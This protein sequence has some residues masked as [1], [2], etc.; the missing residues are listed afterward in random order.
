MTDDKTFNT[1]DRKS[2]LYTA[3]FAAAAVLIESAD[4]YFYN[5]A[6]FG[7]V[8]M[9]FILGVIAIICHV[10]YKSSEVRP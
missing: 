8:I 9:C 4:I 6:Y 1:V 3:V 5:G 7:Y 10:N 2:I